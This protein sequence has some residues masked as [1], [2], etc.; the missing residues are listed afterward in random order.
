MHHRVKNNLQMIAMLLRLQMSE[1]KELSPQN[2]LKETI[3]RVLSIAAVH[4]IL[5]ES[6][7]DK[8]GILNLIRRWRPPS[9]GT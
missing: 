1:N 6:G 3:N 2:I 5:S 9:P 8:V 7:V 4:E